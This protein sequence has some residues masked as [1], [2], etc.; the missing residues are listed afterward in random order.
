MSA[1]G[2]VYFKEKLKKF[3]SKVFILVVQPFE[4]EHI[5]VI[6]MKIL[7][8]KSIKLNVNIHTKTGLQFSNTIAARPKLSSSPSAPDFSSHLALAATLATSL[9]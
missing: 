8:N 7:T 1:A 9:V 5:H 4:L 2:N 3:H 6:S